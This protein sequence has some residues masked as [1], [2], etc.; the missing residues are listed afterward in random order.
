MDTQ[1]EG[2][3][4]YPWVAQLRAAGINVRTGTGE[5]SRDPD[6]SFTLPPWYHPSIRARIGA[7]LRAAW[8]GGAGKLRRL[9]HSK[10]HA[11]VP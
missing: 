7:A 9:T 1:E 5:L 4:E 3:T 8:K 2:R 6:A 11:A 10:R